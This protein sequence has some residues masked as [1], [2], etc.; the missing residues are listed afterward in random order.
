MLK[1]YVIPNFPHIEALGAKMC[2]YLKNATP[3]EEGVPEN[4]VY[5][6]YTMQMFPQVWPSTAGG[7]EEGGA[8][9]GAAMTEEYTTIFSR[10]F[11]ISEDKNKN[12][13]Q[14]SMMSYYIVCFGDDLAYAVVG[15]SSDFFQDLKDL[16]VAS[17]GDAVKKYGKGTIR[18]IHGRGE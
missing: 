12:H 18:I 15:D 10:L 7:M 14:P 2:K 5:F 17:L 6:S 1:P 9:S 4:A 16:D 13:A 3:E 11:Y 8:F